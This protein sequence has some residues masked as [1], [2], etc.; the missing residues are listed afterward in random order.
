MFG[1]SL[2]EEQRLLLASAIEEARLCDRLLRRR[3]DGS[4]ERLA[5]GFR[6]LVDLLL[7]IAAEEPK[8]GAASPQE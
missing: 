7:A 6:V 8:E 2:S 4:V 5:I 1:P 3:S